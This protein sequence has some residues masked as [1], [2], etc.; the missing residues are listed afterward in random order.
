MY[1]NCRAHGILPLS[2]TTKLCKYVS[3]SHTVPT[4]DSSYFIRPMYLSK[5]SH[6]SAEL[7]SA[8]RPSILSIAFDE[9]LA[10]GSL[11]NTASPQYNRTHN[12]PSQSKISLFIY[13]LCYTAIK[14]KSTTEIYIM[15][16]HTSKEKKLIERICQKCCP[17][18]YTYDDDNDDTPNSKSH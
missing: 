7:T 4:K 13:S 11:N 1:N 9:W 16:K 6:T 12:Q 15:Q 17:Q 5:I 10:N 3:M 8:A 2:H 14:S 18:T